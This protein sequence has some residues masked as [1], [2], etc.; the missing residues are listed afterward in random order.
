MYNILIC[1]TLNNKIPVN[2]TKS[3]PGSS[4]EIEVVLVWKEEEWNDK[5]PAGEPGNGFVFTVLKN[6]IRSCLDA[7]FPSLT[8]T[9]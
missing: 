3:A 7:F 9:L 2:I 5:Q 6:Q 8:E 1:I 4:E